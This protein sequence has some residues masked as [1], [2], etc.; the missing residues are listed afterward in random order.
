MS[1]DPI[2]RFDVIKNSDFEP[3]IK[4]G[5]A[6]EDEDIRNIT[7]CISRPTFANTIEKL[8]SAGEL[9]ERVTD[10]FYNLLNAASD[11][12]KEQLAEKFTPILAAH[13]NN[14]MLNQDLFLRVK[15]VY[16]HPLKSLS[17]EK[18]RLTE[19]IYGSF[20]RSGAM[21]KGE[22]R[23]QFRKLTEEASKLTLQFQTNL[24]HARKK[25]SLNIIGKDML[26][27]VPETVLDTAAATARENGE[28]GWT[29]TLDEPVYMPVLTYCNNRELRRALYMAYHGVCLRKGEDCNTEICKDIVNV[30]QKMAQLLGYKSFADYVLEERMAGSKNNV[31][32]MFS[33]LLEHYSDP[34]RKEVSQ[35]E[36]YAK[37]MEGEDFELQPWDF[38]YYSHKLKLSLFDIDSE[39]LRPYFELSKVKEGIFNLATELYG[40]RFSINPDIPVYA[41]GVTAYDVVDKNKTLLGVLFL[42]LHPRKGKQGGAW[43]TTYSPQY[44][45]EKKNHRPCVAIVTNFTPPTPQRPSLLTLGEVTTFLHEFGHALHGLMANTVYRSLSGTNVL[46]DFVELPSQIMENFAVE[47]KFLSTFAQHYQ[48]GEP[49]P[50]ELIDKIVRSRNFNVAYSTMRQV[51]YGLLDMAYYTLEEP[52]GG[53]IEEFEHKAMQPAQLLPEVEN[54]CMTVQFGHIMSG[55]YAAGYYSYKWAELLE[56]D[57]FG[58]FKEHGTF[59]K[60]TAERFRNCILSKGNTEPPMELYKQFRGKE[61]SIDAM[62]ERDGIQKR[63]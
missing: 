8:D 63:Q 52:L 42:D 62:L 47:K 57:A 12:E 48:T 54:T 20:R 50:E 34:A 25:F 41:G 39:M 36:R 2:P 23:K 5:I 19:K 28:N 51:S 45:S 29:I 16:T 9:L 37:S 35:V 18:L 6:E 14:I 40:I 4:Q 21:L 30:R 31:Y 15:Y 44:I 26:D 33:D 32:R 58:E 46:W 49:L 11:E 53:N 1:D 22:D 24:L 60:E 13:Q 56:A 10:V 43:M 59:S 27:G 61:P 55:G 17:P 3:A 38:A 7:S